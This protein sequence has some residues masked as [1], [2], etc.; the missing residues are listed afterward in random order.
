[1]TDIPKAK[2][3]ASVRTKSEKCP[4]SSWSCGVLGD[5][6]FVVDGL[7]AGVDHRAYFEG[8]PAPVAVLEVVILVVVE[9]SVAAPNPTNPGGGVG[10]PPTPLLLPFSDRFYYCAGLRP[11]NTGMELC[12][13][14]WQWQKYFEYMDHAIDTPFFWD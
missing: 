5:A 3:S 10:L 4:T 11:S 1:L 9:C 12:W 7:V 8:Q 13:Q 2:L 6:D 14:R